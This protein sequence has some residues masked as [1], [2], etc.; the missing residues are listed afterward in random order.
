MKPHWRADVVRNTNVAHSVK[1]T[2]QRDVDSTLEISEG[3]SV[4]DAGRIRAIGKA[5]ERRPVKT[6][7]TRKPTI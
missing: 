7:T 1:I 6:V 5:D 3:E 2:K 4:Y